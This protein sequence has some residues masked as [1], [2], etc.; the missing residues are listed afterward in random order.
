MIE[1]VAGMG[2]C[3]RENTCK[4]GER[5]ADGQGRE[6]TGRKHRVAKS[7][8]HLSNTLSTANHQYIIILPTPQ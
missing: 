1:G 8:Q 3:S 7:S 4:V 2:I 6:L 5:G